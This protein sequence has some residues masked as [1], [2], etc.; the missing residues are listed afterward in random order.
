MGLFPEI[1]HVW[2][3]VDNRLF[4]WNYEDQESFASYDFE[5]ENE[6]ILTVVLVTPRPGVFIAEIEYLIALATTSKII[7]LGLRKLSKTADSYEICS[8]P[9]A[10]SSDDI[11]ILSMKGSDDGRLFMCGSDGNLYELEYEVIV[12]YIFL[13]FLF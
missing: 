3:T 2:M 13:L 7:L 4:L 10:V 12:F 11:A 1:G 8:T 6:L 9:L 5:D